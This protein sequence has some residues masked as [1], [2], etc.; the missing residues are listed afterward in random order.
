MNIKS[1]VT[2][3]LKVVENIIENNI[4]N[5]IIIKRELNNILFKEIKSK[6]EI[7]ETLT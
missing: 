2:D 4:K 7:K 3:S 1:L 6:K 5:N